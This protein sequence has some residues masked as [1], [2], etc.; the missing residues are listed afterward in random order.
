MARC[1]LDSR[2]VP[3][4][5]KQIIVVILRVTFTPCKTARKAFVQLNLN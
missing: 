2:R 4:V 5:L 1:I 3:L